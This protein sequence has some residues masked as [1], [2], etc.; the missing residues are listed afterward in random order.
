MAVSFAGGTEARRKVWLLLDFVDENLDASM[1]EIQSLSVQADEIQHGLFVCREARSEAALMI[2][3]PVSGQRLAINI[4][5]V[6]PTSRHR[7]LD[8]DQSGLYPRPPCMVMFAFLI[9][10]RNRNKDER[11]TRKD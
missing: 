2:I 1:F 10:V 4:S 5:Y 9:S 6:P 3:A 8:G 11:T 7:D